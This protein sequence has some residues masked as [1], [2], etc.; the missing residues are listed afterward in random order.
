[1]VVQLAKMR[2]PRFAGALIL[3]CGLVTWSVVTVANASGT[4]P[5]LGLIVWASVALL[6]ASIGLRAATV[7]APRLL[8]PSVIGLCISGGVL[9][10]TPFRAPALIAGVI[11]VISIAA[12]ASLPVSLS[13]CLIGPVCATVAAIA[14]HAPLDSWISACLVFVAS[15]APGFARRSSR[16]HA[17]QVELTLVQ[18]R[19]TAEAE[20]SAA[21][22][23]ERARIARE[24]HDVLAHSLSALSLTLNAAEGFL[25]STPMDPGTTRALECVRRAKALAAEAGTETRTVI[26][27]LRDQ[28]P[29]V[30]R[31]RELIRSDHTGGSSS[32]RLKVIGLESELPAPVEH[33]LYRAVQESLTNARKHGPG[34]PAEVSLEYTHDD[35]SVAVRNSVSHG[36]MS[37]SPST[38]SS[39]GFGLIGLAERARELGGTF[40]FGASDGF[41]Q[42]RMR[43][44]R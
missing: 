10:V 3:G 9:A 26:R 30:H 20:R 2:W 34:T 15:L 38:A 40:T 27:T 44:P 11:A 4:E 42:T 35:V 22:A 24:T 6:A 7:I 37:T 17:E 32:V 21:A 18:E 8:L 12:E 25:L 41:W 19:R 36:R 31:L 39:S 1:V 43:L 28:Q 16:M 13:V 29:L 14:T 5:N 33:A 23:A